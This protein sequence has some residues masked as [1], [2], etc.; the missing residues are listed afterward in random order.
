MKITLTS[1]TELGSFSY[2]SNI[3]SA[4]KLLAPDMKLSEDFVC[5]ENDAAAVADV[6]DFNSVDFPSANINEEYDRPPF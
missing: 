1:G 6:E 2:I 5:V 4:Y 3:L